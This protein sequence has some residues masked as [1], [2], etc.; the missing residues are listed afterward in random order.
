MTDTIDDAQDEA[1][2]VTLFRMTM[3]ERQNPAARAGDNQTS[4]SVLASLSSGD[5]PFTMLRL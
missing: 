5:S 4:V 2:D 3:E 1:E